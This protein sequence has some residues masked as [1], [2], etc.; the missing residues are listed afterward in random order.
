MSSVENAQMKTK[1]K[2]S[3]LSRKDKMHYVILWQ[4]EGMSDA[5]MRERFGYARQHTLSSLRAD[6]FFKSEVE[7]V[8]HKLKSPVGQRQYKL[9]DVDKERITKLSKAGNNY[10]QIAGLTGINYWVI[11]YYA[12]KIGLPSCITRR[13]LTDDEKS[14]I[15]RL[16][17]SG[18][19]DRQIAEKL[20]RYISTVQRYLQSVIGYRNALPGWN[21]I[22]K[23]WQKGQN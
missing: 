10:R 4:S 3:A 18:L 21:S 12:K 6:P 17:E 19:N 20:G 13:R 5:E 2:Y 23:A 1:T 8:A 14:E 15:L 11:H 22:T 16:N 9:T 7:R